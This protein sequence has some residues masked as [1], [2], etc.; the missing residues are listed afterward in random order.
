MVYFLWFNKES[1]FC[2]LVKVT[3]LNLMQLPNGGP[4]QIEIF[5]YWETD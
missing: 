3:D 2:R 5:I 4:S 1:D